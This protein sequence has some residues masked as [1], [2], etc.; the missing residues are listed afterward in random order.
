MNRRTGFFVTT[1]TGVAALFALTSCQT[2]AASGIAS[3]VAQDIAPL[4]QLPETRFTVQEF[5]DRMKTLASDEF[6]GRAPGSQGETKTIDYLIAQAK[7]IGLQPAFG[8]SYV[9]TVPMAE[10]QTDLGTKLN[11]TTPAGK[12]TYSFSKDMVIGTTTGKPLVSLKNSDVVFVGYGVNAPELGWNDYAGLDVKGKTVVMLVNDPGFHTKDESLFEGRRM[13]YYG[14][15]TYKFEE[16][17]RQG[18]AAAFI[19]HDNEGAAYGWQVVDNGWTG[20]QFDLTPADDPA[21]RLPVRG[22]LTQATATQLFADAG[23]RLADQYAAASRK[24][25]TSIP[26]KAKASAELKTAVTRKSSQNFAAI[27]PGTKRPD[28]AIVYQ[29]HWD[30]LGVHSGGKPG[31]DHIYNGA[32]DNASGVAAIMTIAEG[33]ARQAEKPERSIVVFAP[34]LE[35]SGLLGS[36]YF[37]A[38]P[39]VA[40]KKMVAVINIDAMTLAGKARNLVVIGNGSSELEDILKPYAAIQGRELA[41][42]NTPQDGFFFRSDHFN[43]A[44]AGVPALYVKGGDDLLVGGLEAGRKIQENYRLNDYHKPSDDYRA[45]WNLEGTMQDLQVLYAVG[46]EL[47][48][49]DRWPLWYSTNAFRT[50]QDALRK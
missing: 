49:S 41:P 44:K 46:R 25:F 11:I 14:R 12:R 10:S 42:E 30:H 26:L 39:P 5:A 36:A 20:K 22:W 35:E 7:Q 32:V 28:E 37:V 13:T 4:Q 47:A 38:H 33:F 24:G 23:L 40:L 29:G 21:P 31:E 50:K 6:L 8:N 45:N 2:P 3:D 1:L 16:A 15:W 17:A 19:V 9:Q 27:L 18:A 48:F 43:F 34:T